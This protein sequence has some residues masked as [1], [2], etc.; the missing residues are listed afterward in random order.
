MSSPP[1]P[2][3]PRLLTP[4]PLHPLP[5]VWALIVLLSAAYFCFTLIEKLS[6]TLNG[7][8][9]IGD[10]FWGLPQVVCNVTFIFWIYGALEKTL[11]ELKAT[12]Q[13]VKLNM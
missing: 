1:S 10:V 7:P 6:Q 2:P 12:R 8:D 5:Q 9:N 4:H 11:K 13:S 3:S